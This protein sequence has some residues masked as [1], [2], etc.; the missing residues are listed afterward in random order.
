MKKSVLLACI[1]VLL[2]FGNVIS[3]DMPEVAILWGPSMTMSP[4]EFSDY[5]Q[6]SWWNITAGYEVPL[7]GSLSGII[8]LDYH[9]YSFNREAFQDDFIN[10]GLGADTRR[11]KVKSAG[12]S[13][14]IKYQFPLSGTITGYVLGGGGVGRYLASDMDFN[15]AGTINSESWMAIGRKRT[16]ATV[17]G[18]FGFGFR[19]E[20]G[21]FLFMEI[22]YQH[23]FTPNEAT[24]T[25][26]IKFGYQF[27]V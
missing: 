9:K 10:A 13:F 22:M 5:W 2:G 6:P 18:G 19:Q 25:L 26:P 24:A 27:V 4:T 15:A 20:D 7:M 16:S 1:I 23:A 3:Q 14:D 11:A 8:R 12:V 17:Q 21:A